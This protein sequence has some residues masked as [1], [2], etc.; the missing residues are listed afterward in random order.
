MKQLQEAKVDGVMI[1]V[2]WG[3][4]EATGPKIYEW[5]A[6]R[7]LFQMVKEEGL[8]L[9]AIM[10]FH[11]CR[12]N[13]GDKVDIPIPQ[14]V[15]DIGLYSDFMKS[16]RKNMTDF[17]DGSLI[18]DIE[19]GLG[20]AGEM[21]YPSYPQNQGWVFP[22]IGEFQCYDKYLEANFKATAAKVGL[23]EWELP[24]DAGEYNHTPDATK[25]FS[26]DGT[27]TT[28]K[29]K[30][31]LTWYSNKLIEHADQIL[32]E[33]N[34]AFLGC[35]MKLAAKVLS[36]AWREGIE[37]ACENALNQYDRKAYN[38][39]LK[40]ARPNGL[41]PRSTE[42]LQTIKPLERSKPQIPI[43]KI[44]EASEMLKPYPFDPETDM[45][46]GGDIA[47]FIDGK[48]D[49]IFYKITSILN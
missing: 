29:G 37:A 48:F 27:Y 22:G 12:G 1:D 14:W 39:I 13:I 43:E 8:K 26:A 23:P 25:F 33:A 49:K 45:S 44:L 20:P 9:Q 41:L 40:N 34:Q 21:R 16:F 19:V 15:W 6:Y 30:F 38:Q 17:L 46:V 35:K 47:D 4:I 24:D 5:G 28:E 3:I 10:L 11:Q 36:A 2:W 18:T 7:Q 31:F 32:D 42:V